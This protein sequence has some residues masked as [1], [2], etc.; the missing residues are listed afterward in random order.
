MAEWSTHPSTVGTCKMSGV[1]DGRETQTGAQS[2]NLISEFGGYLFS[3]FCGI[4]DL[5]KVF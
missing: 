2:L 5:K 1:P 3:S 4:L